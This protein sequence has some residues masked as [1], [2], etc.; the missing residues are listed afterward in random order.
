MRIDSQPI[1]HQDYDV[2]VTGSSGFIGS[3]IIEAYQ[4]LE[5]KVLGID[6]VPP[7]VNAGNDFLHHDLVLP[8]DIK[9][10]SQIIVHCAAAVG[11]LLKNFHSTDL[12][13]YNQK[14][15]DNINSFYQNNSISSMIYLSSI[16]VFENTQAFTHAPLEIAPSKTPY[17]ISKA[18]GEKLFTDMGNSL[19]VV[20]P[21][22]VFGKSQEKLNKKIGESHVI[23]DLIYK[24]KTSKTLNVLGNGMQKRNFL[25]VSDLVHFIINYQFT[26]SNTFINLRSNNTLSI[27]ELVEDLLAFYNKKMEIK[28]DSSYMS[29]ENFEI[30]N[31][32]LDHPSLKSW[33]PKINTIVEGLE[34]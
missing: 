12:I 29:Y 27:N 3:Q 20:R 25:H 21:T 17:A 6:I 31:F 4:R 24:I 2:I 1:K 10:S 30:R 26:D 19:L 33:K 11:G 32:D 23:P 34:L 16:N 13:A 14:I 28:Y 8:L 7:R 9:L 5:K 18:F 15:N 22:N